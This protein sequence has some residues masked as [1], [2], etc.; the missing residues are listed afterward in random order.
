MYGATAGLASAAGRGPAGCHPPWVTTPGEAV[1]GATGRPP[2]GRPVPGRLALTPTPMAAMT[3]VTVAAVTTLRIPR[4]QARLRRTRMSG[5]GRVVTGL[6]Q[7]A[8]CSCSESSSIGHLLV[9]LRELAVQPV[10]GRRQ[11]GP[12]R[13]HRN[14]AVACDVIDREIG[15]VIQHQDL[16][17]G[18]RQPHQ[19]NA[20]R[21]GLQRVMQVVPAA[22]RSALPHGEQR[23]HD[24]DPA[25]PPGRVDGEPERDLPHPGLGQLVAGDS[26]PP[27][28]RPG[29][30]LLGDV[31]GLVAVACYGGYHP[32]HAAVAGLVELPEVIGL[33]RHVYRHA[34]GRCPYQP[35]LITIRTTT[36]RP[37]PTF[38]ACAV[39]AGLPRRT[40]TPPPGAGSRTG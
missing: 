15:Q 32:D 20:Q 11:P 31:L 38:R 37:G 25:R 1:R 34:R 35:D 3:M 8:S 28:Q 40:S 17:L 36:L 30:S 24:P 13:A 21:R 33:D 14:P 4:R 6:T 22:G 2:A 26:V 7:S 39:R 10:P 16:A 19:G 5:M 23:G 29:E 12:D 9:G 18:E 27:G